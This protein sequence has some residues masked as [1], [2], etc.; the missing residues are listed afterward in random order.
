[1]SHEKS[2]PLHTMLTIVNHVLTKHPELAPSVENLSQRI[3][4]KGWGTTLENEVVT[5]RRFLPSPPY[6][7][8][9]IGGNVGNF[10]AAL[11]AMNS[12]IEVH[13]FEPSMINVKKLVQRFCNDKKVHIQPF[14]VSDSEYE[15]TLFSDELG[16]G[17]ASLTK[18]NLAHIGVSFELTERV[19]TVALENYWNKNLARKHI[20]L[21][22]I[23]IEGH[24]I[25][26]LRGLGE[27]IHHVSV[28]Q[29]EF[30]GTCID[31]RV[32]FR[33]FWSVLSDAGFDIFRASPNGAIRIEKYSENLES[34]LHANYIAAKKA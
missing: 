18:R 2:N 14:A 1:M 16:S 24:E 19:K 29:F 3:Q 33:D 9:D 20:D 5:L 21:L 15:T 11:R 31:S 12:E 30:G 32:F 4:G 25:D 13:I 27:A 34:F 8:I 17:M 26:A 6:L 7:A 28:I 22:K 23:D 10:T